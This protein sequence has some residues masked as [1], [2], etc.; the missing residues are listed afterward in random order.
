M[1]RTWR[2]LAPWVNSTLHGESR[3]LVHG[4]FFPGSW[5]TD[6][7]RV[8]VI[9]PEFCFLGARE[10]DFGVMAGHLLLAH[11]PVEAVA[12]VAAAAEAHGADRALAAGFAGV[13]VMRRLIGVAQLPR[14][15]LTLDAKQALLEIVAPSGARRAAAGRRVIPPGPRSAAFPAAASPDVL[16][17]FT[18]APESGRTKTRLIP[19][20]GAEGAAA[21]HRAMVERTLGTARA[22]RQHWPC[23]LEVRLDGHPPEDRTGLARPRR[24]HRRA[25]RG[26]AGRAHGQRL[27]GPLPLGRGARRAGGHRRP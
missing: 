20:L 24:R 12:R 26:L 6:G 27:R 11:Q 17:V 10:F 25:G 18:R 8:F 14:L 16:V 3:A 2:V 23:R 1:R 22:M 4:D 19:A 21:L 15:R 5:L 13:E 7:A 9:D